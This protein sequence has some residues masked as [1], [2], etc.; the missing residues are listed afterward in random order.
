MKIL[1]CKIGDNYEE[2]PCWFNL[3]I[4]NS[5]VYYISDA[6]HMLKL[7]RNTLGNNHVLEFGANDNPNV[8]QFKTA[9]KQI[10]LKNAELMES[11]IP[12]MMTL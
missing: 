11:V 6:C 12:L 9:M 2:I 5:R 8:T 3:P 7:A 1:G 10:L 4:D